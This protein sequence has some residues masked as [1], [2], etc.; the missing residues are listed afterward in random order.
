MTLA[1]LRRL[2][3]L[4]QKRLK[5]QDWKLD[6]RFAADMA[7]T[8]AGECWWHPDNRTA[9]IHILPPHIIED[10]IEETLVHE[11]LHVL[12]EGHAWNTE[13]SLSVHQE[14]AHNQAA[15]ALVSAY[16]RKKK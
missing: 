13:D 1:T 6:V 9:E 12:Y 4:W 11:L 2:T 7:D 5:L 10:D 3:K 16:S 15:A 14:R 8:S